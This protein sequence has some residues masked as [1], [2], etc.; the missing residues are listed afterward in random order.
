MDRIAST[1]QETYP[2]TNA[3]FGVTVELMG[4]VLV[5][6]VRTPL[7]LMFGAVGFVLLTPITRGLIAERVLANVRVVEATG[8]ASFGGMRAGSGTPSPVHNNDSGDSRII[9]GE[10]SASD[11]SAGND[12]ASK[13]S[14]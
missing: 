10:F 7:L 13:T 8:G 2:E 4:T 6:Y 3:N 14:G 5:Y 1:L 11:D 12:S 9:E